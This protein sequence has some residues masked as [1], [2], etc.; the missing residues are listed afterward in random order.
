MIKYNKSPSRKELLGV[1][2]T[3]VESQADSELLP[4]S[5]NSPPEVLL[6]KDVP[7]ICSK[8]TGEHPY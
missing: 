7:K 5:R 8:F 2:Q 6:G 3:H 1:N 4:V